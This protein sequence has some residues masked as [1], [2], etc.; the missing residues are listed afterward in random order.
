MARRM[1]RKII[2]ALLSALIIL[3]C[4]GEDTGEI[5]IV[6]TADLLA[7]P[8]ECP[9]NCDDMVEC[10]GFCPWGVPFNHEWFEVESEYAY[11]YIY[12]S[13]QCIDGGPFVLTGPDGTELWRLWLPWGEEHGS[14]EIPLP[15]IGRYHFRG[16]FDFLGTRRIIYIY[17][18]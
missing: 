1:N 8:S 2:Y 16:P 14:V 4:C 7:S 9:A 5:E 13:I 17:G 6:Y 18:L 10:M 12:Y 15:E 11:L 3:P